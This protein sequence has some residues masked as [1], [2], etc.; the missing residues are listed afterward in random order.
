MSYTDPRRLSWDTSGRHTDADATLAGPLEER[1]LL[2]VLDPKHWIDGEMTKRLAEIVVELLSNGAFN[3]LSHDVAFA[4]LSKSRIGYGVDVE[5]ADFLVDELKV[6]G[7]ARPSEDG[8]SIPLHPTVRTTILV[9]LGQ[10]SRIA[11]EKRGVTIHPATNDSLAVAD[12]IETLSREKMPSRDR[13]VSLDLEPV[14]F[15]LASVPLDDVLQFRA[16][17]K[18][19][20]RAYMRDLRSFVAELAEI[21]ERGEREVALLERRQEI[22][23]AAHDLQRSM[24]R[25]L[26]KNLGS[27]FLGITGGVW[28][29]TAGDLFGLVLSAVGVGLGAVP[30]GSKNVSAYSYIFRASRTFGMR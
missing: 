2:R 12:L 5:L 21:N 20:H 30:S 18:D 26:G 11:G 17:H 29:W 13:V 7:L 19:A 22:A 23:D 6:Q 9:I 16:E 1:G 4:E 24:R 14:T 8:V 25:A 15:D 27:W 28:S 3:D 10:L